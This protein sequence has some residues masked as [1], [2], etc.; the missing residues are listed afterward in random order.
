[1]RLLETIPADTLPATVAAAGGA[2]RLRV[3][4]TLSSLQVGGAERNVVSLLPYLEREGLDVALCT[5]SKRS[6]SYLAN[7]AAR[8]D[9]PRYNLD[10]RKLLDL[11]GFHRFLRLLQERNVD[12]IHAEDQYATLYSSVASLL[13][14]IPWVATRHN[15]A[16]EKPDV[17]SRVR[18]ELC[19][20]ALRGANRCIT[21]SDAIR[22]ALS[23]KRVLPPERMITVYN[24]VEME[25]FAT[26]GDLKASRRALNW[27]LDDAIVLVVAVIREDKGHDLL[28]E[29]TKRLL[30]TVPNLCIKVVGDGPFRAVRQREAA[31]LGDRVE[32]MGQRSDV[33]LLL[34]ASDLLVMPSRNEGLPT[35]LIEA[36]AAGLPVVATDV[37]GTREIVE[38]DVT[39]F[40]VPPNDVSALSQRMAELMLNPDLAKRL[41]HA[42]RERIKQIFTLSNQARK[43]AAVYNELVRPQ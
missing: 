2:R 26:S 9:V 28:F 43:T 30:A 32:F 21:V 38:H 8:T 11:S 35:V 20:V 1:M 12:I 6:D 5:L 3:L 33:P 24:G 23:E 19:L 36:A 39:G 31:F 41:G 4:V 18:A 29:A 22:R 7:I 16:E 40:V 15:V 34:N 17:R 10:A 42:G 37:G 13:T 25:K 27:P 14:G